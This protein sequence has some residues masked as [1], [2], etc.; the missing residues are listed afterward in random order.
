M[1][2]KLERI[3]QLVYK[4]WRAEK[5]RITAPHP[6][7]EALA[8]FLENK[9]T[10]KES[11]TIKE[12]II[13]CDRC[14]ERVYLYA[15][16]KESEALAVPEELLKRVKN[17]LSQAESTPILEVFLKLKE[18]ALELLHTTGDILVGQEFMPAPILRSRQIK[19]F[20]DEII[21]LKDF[22][23]IRAE[24]KIENKLGQAFSLTVMIKEKQTSRTIKDLRVTLLKENVE[25]ESYV[26]D[27]GRVVFEHVLIGKYSISVFSAEKNLATIQLDI[28]V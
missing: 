25:L 7:E 4:K 21:I 13:N 15:S 24:L 12:H 5:G 8:C 3:I 6:D 2:G 28:T 26:T 23:D 22:Q 16:T 14:S 10:E 18:K 17:L 11:K 19:D 1:Q 27:S 20:K 9:L